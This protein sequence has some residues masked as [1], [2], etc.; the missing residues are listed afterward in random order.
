M[1]L[2]FGNCD[3]MATRLESRA[4]SCKNAKTEFAR[5]KL[6]I[7]ALVNAV[8]RI[9]RRRQYKGFWRNKV[10]AY[11]IAIMNLSKISIKTYNSCIV[12]SV[13]SKAFS[14]C[15]QFNNYY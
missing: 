13:G 5:G 12:F 7:T 3:P 11:P 6:I 8:M 9:L 10:I 15:S 4:V 14:F 2:I 1:S